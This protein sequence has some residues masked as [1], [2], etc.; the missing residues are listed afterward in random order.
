[1]SSLEA[2]ILLGFDAQI[3]AWAGLWTLEL[4]FNWGLTRST[5]RPKAWV[6]VYDDPGTMHTVAAT[7]LLGFRFR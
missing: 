2:G 6:D 5:E 4:R 3:D 7:L 1:M